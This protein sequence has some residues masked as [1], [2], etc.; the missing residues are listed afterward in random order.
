MGNLPSQ[1]VEEDEV[2]DF[3]LEKA[4]QKG[5][6]SER[7]ENLFD[8]SILFNTDALH[9]AI[10][11]IKEAQLSDIQKKKSEIEQWIKNL[12]ERDEKVVSI[13]QFVDFLT[14]KNIDR[15]EAVDFF[16]ELDLDGDGSV[17]TTFLLQVI[18]IISFRYILY[19]YYIKCNCYFYSL[20]YHYC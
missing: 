2:G 3:E 9:K 8:F 14:S 12:I 13:A 19:C 11:S 5:D 4:V 1:L 17:E 7:E 18:I 10:V 20:C 6:V 15:E 16:N